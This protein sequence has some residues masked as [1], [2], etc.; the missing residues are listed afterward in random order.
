MLPTLLAHKRSSGVALVSIMARLRIDS[1]WDRALTPAFVYF[2]KLLYPFA[3]VQQPPS[4]ADCRGRGRL[5]FGGPAR[6]SRRSVRSP[7]CE[8]R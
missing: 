5:H 3:G 6:P 1:A 8:A 2:F 4:A 7:R